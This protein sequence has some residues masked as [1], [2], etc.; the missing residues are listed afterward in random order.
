MLYEI[1]TQ[2]RQ[3]EAAQAVY[4]LLHNVAAIYA[5]YLLGA[6]IMAHIMDTWQNMLPH[7]AIMAYINNSNLPNNIS[8]VLEQLQV[9]WAFNLILDKQL[10]LGMS[11]A[12]LSEKIC[13][14]GNEN[15][16]EGSPVETPTSGSVLALEDAAS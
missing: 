3:A 8:S 12:D 16:T 6:I 2:P 1:F 14:P 11:T 9:G 15:I 13:Q 4:T 5:S 7:D 10:I